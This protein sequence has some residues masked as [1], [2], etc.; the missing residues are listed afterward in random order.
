M[1]NLSPADFLGN[2]PFAVLDV[3]TIGL[4]SASGHRV[5]EVALLRCRGGKVL[6]TFESPINPQ[7]PISPSA[8]TVNRLTDWD[9]ADRFLTLATAR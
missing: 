9:D 3:E 7:R 8:T 1:S 6:D 4:N 5:C 2:T